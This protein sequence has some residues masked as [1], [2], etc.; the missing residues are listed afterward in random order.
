MG[1]VEHDIQCF[2]YCASAAG[3]HTASPLNSAYAIAGPLIMNPRFTSAGC[4]TRRGGL[5]LSVRGLAIDGA[6][7]G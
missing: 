3:I 1:R 2:D 6:F 7:R 5:P 4:L